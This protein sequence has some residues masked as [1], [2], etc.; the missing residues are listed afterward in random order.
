[1]TDPEATASPQSAKSKTGNIVIILVIVVFTLCIC[2][3]SVGWMMGVT[4]IGL[5]GY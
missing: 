3:A 4:G 5:G 2:A 1:M